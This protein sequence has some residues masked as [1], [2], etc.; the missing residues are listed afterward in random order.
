MWSSGWVGSWGWTGVGG[1]DQFFDVQRDGG[2]ELLDSVHGMISVQGFAEM[3]MG[4]GVSEA[5]LDESSSGH[6]GFEL[7][8]L[9]EGEAGEAEALGEGVDFDGA[10][11]TV[12]AEGV[13]GALVGEGAAVDDG[14]VLA[15]AMGA[16]DHGGVVGADELVVFVEDEQIGGIDAVFVVSLRG[17]DE[18]LN[19]VGEEGFS[20]V[21]MVV[22]FIGGGGF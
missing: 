19:A 10:S 4:F 20:D 11:W 15:G 13:V 8:G 5:C 2:G 21:G 3:M 6:G 17:V 18:G 22:A 14:A 12:G 9:F 7:G 16:G 1:G